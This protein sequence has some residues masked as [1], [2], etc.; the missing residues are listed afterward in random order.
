MLILVA[1]LGSTSFKYQLWDMD[2]DAVLAR[3]WVENIGHEQSRLGV[4]VDGRERVQTRVVADHGV[5]VEACFDQLT[6]PDGGA[7]ADAAEIGAIGFKA[8]HGGRLSGAHRVDDSV[9]EAMAEMNAAAPAHNPPYIAAMRSLGERFPDMP[10]VAAFE[11][12]FHQTVPRSRRR[13]GIPK[14]WDNDLKLQ[15]YGFHG[16]SHRYIGYRMAEILDRE[17]AKVISCHLGG[18]SSVTAIDGGQSVL[19]SMGLTPQTG[20]PQNN[21]VG[22]FDAYAIPIIRDATG[23][24]VDEVLQ[25]LASEGGLL[26]ISDL[27]SDIRQIHAAAAEGNE[28]CRLAIATYVEEVRRYIGASMTALGCVDAIAFTGGIGEN[29]AIIRAGVTANLESFG[30]VLDAAA[31]HAAVGETSVHAA[32]SSTQIWTI[33]AGEE[34]VVARQTLAVLEGRDP[35]VLRNPR[36]DG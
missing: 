11:T 23:L 18:S 7:V 1:N 10:L 9:L 3:G 4:V 21:R 5:A 13:Y 2:H 30:I 29:D 19:T 32:E 35:S 26:G 33:P 20:L 28:D 24:S 17:D 12:G 25:T 31:N 8:V 36:T 15:R 14:R 6:D 16:A 34:F 22:D 27:S